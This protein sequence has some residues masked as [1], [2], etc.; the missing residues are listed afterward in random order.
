MAIT[1]KEPITTAIK[2]LKTAWTQK[3]TAIIKDR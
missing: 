3:S 1:I 2:E